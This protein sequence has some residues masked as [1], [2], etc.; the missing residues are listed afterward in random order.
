MR[1]I[2]TDNEQ[3]DMILLRDN[4]KKSFIMKISKG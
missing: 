4:A 3:Y 1:C 2:Y